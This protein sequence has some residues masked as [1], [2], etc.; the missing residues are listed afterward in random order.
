M[1]H[2]LLAML[3]LMFLEAGAAFRLKKPDDCGV[4]VEGAVYRDSAW[5]QTE[6]CKCPEDYSVSGADK[7]CGDGS[8]R[9]FS[10][11]PMREKGCRCVKNKW[12]HLVTTPNGFRLNSFVSKDTGPYFRWYVQQQMHT[13]EWKGEA[14]DN[15][16]FYEVASSP[17]SMHVFRRTRERSC[18]I[19]DKKDP[20]LLQIGPCDSKGLVPLLRGSYQKFWI[21]EFNETEGYALA[22]G[23]DP[24]VPTAHG[25]RPSGIKEDGL[26]ILTLQQHPPSSLIEHVRELAKAQGFDIGVLKQVSQEGCPWW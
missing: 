6:P 15:W 5:R 11:E 8:M 23:G 4:V 12:C 13:E 26:W 10:L 3:A 14:C 18:A 22:S 17:D 19:A 24:K 25:C 1:R 9:Y 7:A 16:Q 21:L 20:A 2:W